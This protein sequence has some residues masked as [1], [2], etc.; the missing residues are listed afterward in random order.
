MKNKWDKSIYYQKELL[1]YLKIRN[2]TDVCEISRRREF[3]EDTQGSCIAVSHSDCRA[4]LIP[5]DD[6][7]S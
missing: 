4:K 2:L 5:M 6:C 3:C 7:F 1:F